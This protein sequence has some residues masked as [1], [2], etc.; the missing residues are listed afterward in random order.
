MVVVMMMVLMLVMLG[1]GGSL[2]SCAEVDLIVLVKM[3]V[4]VEEIVERHSAEE[5]SE[6]IHRIFEGKVEM[7]L[8]WMMVMV[9]AM[10]MSRPSLRHEGILE[11][12]AEVFRVGA[13][14]VETGVTKSVV[15]SALLRVRKNL[16]SFTN[17]FKFL[18][19]K[20]LVFSSI[21]IRM[22]L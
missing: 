5:L 20:L 1:C 17:F 6:Y 4:R 9:V 7:R 13:I 8:P 14:L 2:V 18:I 10:M 15:N 3:G 22:P 19:G 21:L 16:V 11:S 12:E